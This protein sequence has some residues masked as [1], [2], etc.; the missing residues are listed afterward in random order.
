M[1]NVQVRCINKQPRND[2]HEGITHLG[3]ENWKWTRAQVIASIEA[4]TNSFYTLVSGNRA[5]VG[6]V[7]GANGKYVRTYPAPPLPEPTKAEVEKN[8]NEL[9]A[10][11][12]TLAKPCDDMTTAATRAMKRGDRY[13]AYSAAAGARD[14]CRSAS[15][16]VLDLSKSWE[17]PV[18]AQFRSAIAGCSAAYLKVGSAFGAVSKA[19]NSMSPSDVSYAQ[20]AQLM[21]QVELVSCPAD[22]VAAAAANDVKLKAPKLK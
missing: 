11:F 3:G 2:T 8:A 18:P 6:V 13:G 21:A 16:T 4:G 9:W 10:K 12:Q 5:T 7:N 1:A 14:V 20:Q 17:G 19:L 15:I 22:Y